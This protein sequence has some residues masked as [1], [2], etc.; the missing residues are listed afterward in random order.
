[1]K[2]KIKK[3]LLEWIVLLSVFGIIYLAGWHTEVIG[4]IQQVVLSTGIIQPSIVDEE[5]TASYDFM[6]EDL[7]GKKV[8]FEEFKGEVVFINFWATWCPPCVAEMPDIHRLY[9]DQ[10]DQVRFIMISL[11]Q[12]EEKAHK[13]ISKKGFDFPVYFLRSP[14]PANFNTRSIPTTYVLDKKGK[15]K[16]EN[17][18]M[19]KY[20]TDSFRQLLTELSEVK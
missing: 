1:M 16:V 13:F 6:I 15:I 11:D 14:L 3:E 18:G 5:K 4:R 2:Q 8:Q 17:H 10:K 7:D 20:N 19:A 12:D 9:E